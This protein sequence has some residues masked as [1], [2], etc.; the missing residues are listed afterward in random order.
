MLD[1]SVV[2]L[3]GTYHGTEWPPS[4]A[5]FFQALISGSRCRFRRG[6]GWRSEFDDAL[7]WLEAQPPP[8]IVAPPHRVGSSYL[9]FGPDNDMDLWVRDRLSEARGRPSKKPTDPATL[10]SQLERRPTYASGEVH[11]LYPDAGAHFPA[12]ETMANSLLALGHGIDLASGRA[13]VLTEKESVGLK[14]ERWVPDPGGT[15]RLYAPVPGWYGRLEAN[16]RK[17]RLPPSETAHTV[18]ARRG[19]V[20]PSVRGVTYREPWGQDFR[21]IHAFAL[22]QLEDGRP[23][24]VSWEDAMEVSGQL[25]HAVSEVFRSDGADESFLRVYVLG[26]GEGE[27]RDRRLSYAPLPSIGHQ[28]VDGRVRRVLV[29]GPPGPWDS[30]AGSLS[31]L[32]DGARLAAPGAAAKACLVPVPKADPV[33]A[34]YLGPS[35]SWSSVTPVILHGHDER[36]GRVDIERTRALLEQAFKQAVLGA[37]VATY[38]YRNAPWWPGTGSARS[39]RVPAHLATWPRYHIRVELRR[40]MRGPLLVGIGRHYGIGLFAAGP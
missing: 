33:L 6:D 23:F 8:V 11:Y 31:S 35:R 29:V 21:P 18:D 9:L 25:R 19:T 1:L 39:M 27:E 2:L 28:H 26:H 15:E 16:Y 3:A 38:V 12:L 37:S 32:L 22:E 34:R 24:S 4:P 10:R 40:E 30:R 5:R 13:R 20:P 17:W 36:R 7:L 14:G